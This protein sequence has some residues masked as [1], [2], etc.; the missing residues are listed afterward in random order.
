MYEFVSDYYKSSMEGKIYLNLVHLI[1][2]HDSAHLDEP[3]DLVVGGKELNDG[4]NITIYLPIIRVSRTDPVYA[5]LSHRGKVL[6]CGGVQIV[7]KWVIRETH[8]ETLGSI[9]IV[10]I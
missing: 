3:S 4:F 2:T 6:K 1:E 9:L 10:K 8:V 5:E 7:G